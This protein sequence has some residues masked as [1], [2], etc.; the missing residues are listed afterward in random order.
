[1]NL[2]LFRNAS[3]YSNSLSA[4]GEISGLGLIGNR[5][6]DGRDKICT[7]AAKMLLDYPDMLR[8]STHRSQDYKQFTAAPG[9]WA[10]KM[11]KTVV[12]ATHECSE[13][14]FHAPISGRAV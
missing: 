4:I 1:M 2:Q 3:I 8:S 13:E 6:E 14:P 5:T 7:A 12:V 9:R 10:R 11:S